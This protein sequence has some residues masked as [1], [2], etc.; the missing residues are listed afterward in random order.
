MT[1]KNNIF[2]NT[3]TR[4]SS[5]LAF[6]C[7]AISFLCSERFSFISTFISYSLPR[8]MGL[9]KYHGLINFFKVQKSLSA[10][11]KIL[12]SHTHF[13]T[14]I[15]DSRVEIIYVMNTNMNFL[16]TSSIYQAIIVN[17]Q[18][19]FNFSWT[20]CLIEWMNERMKAKKNRLIYFLHDTLYCGGTID[21]VS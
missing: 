17:S 10:R 9:L 7:Q 13:R 2:I 12:S 3:F 4:E 5:S 6:F 14:R 1:R 15:T 8:A 20:E 16:I 11:L 18:S 19:L 21:R